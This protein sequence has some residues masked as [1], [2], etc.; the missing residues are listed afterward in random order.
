MLMSASSMSGAMALVS[1]SPLERMNQ[2]LAQSWSLIEPPQSMDEALAS[3]AQL[4]SL[5][6]RTTMGVP[7]PAPAPAPAR[8][9]AAVGTGSVMSSPQ[10]TVKLLEMAMAMTQQGK[11]PSMS[12]TENLSAWVN[13]SMSSSNAASGLTRTDAVPQ[14]PSLAKPVLP[15]SVIEKSVPPVLKDPETPVESAPD[16]PREIPATPISDVRWLVPQED[17]QH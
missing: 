16:A 12:D 11:N 17:R 2:R 6:S 15:N 5:N 8:G 10:T 13:R 3:S 1:S 9:V 14:S 7:A 4:L